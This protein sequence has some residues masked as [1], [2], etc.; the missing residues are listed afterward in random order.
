[1]TELY[2]KALLVVSAVLFSLPLTAKVTLP[3]F[4][5]S[6]MVL[7][8]NT[9]VSLPCRTSPG[10]EVTIST[11]FNNERE[12]VTADADGRFTYIIEV[13]DASMTPFWIRFSDG[14]TTLFN[15]LYSGEVWLCGGQSNMEMPIQGWGCVQNYEQEVANANYPMIRLL[16]VS[17]KLAFSPQEDAA[18]N[19][20]GW[21][22]CSPE[23]AANFS[24]LA[25]FFGREL[26][27]QLNVPIGLVYSAW[28]GTPCESWVS[29]ETAREVGGFESML[30]LYEQCGFDRDAILARDPNAENFQSPTLEYNAM[31]YPLRIMPIAGA[32]WYQGESNVGRDV[33]YSTLFKALINNWREIWNNDFPFYFVQLAGYLQPVEVQPGS[34]WAAL[35]WAQQKALE[36]P[37][38][39]MA[40]AIDVGNETDI[41]PK[42]KQEVGR[43]LALVA[44]KNTYGLD[45][46]DKAPALT[47]YSLTKRKAVLTFSAPLTV[48]ET[49][50][51]RGFILQTPTGSFVKGRATLE[52]DSTVSVTGTFTGTPISVRYNWADFPNGNLYGANDLPV[53]PFRTDDM[54]GVLN[55]IH[56]VTASEASTHAT[57]NVYTTDGILLRKG[58]ESGAAADDLPAGV[59]IVGSKK[60]LV[61]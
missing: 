49:I 20:G 34:Q 29:F 11:S 16:Q 6:G 32:I 56:S 36:L 8:H 26:Y 15:D 51:P 59:Y 4:F 53:L 25:Y 43:R 39:G 45:V 23:T 9:T 1:M 12:T 18:V 57:V 21:Q 14:E 58:V 50:Q 13:P 35:R 24:A 7:Q 33:Q 48:K 3:S 2:S 47:S 61:K 28:G 60:V 55:G 30:N 37:N 54:D 40:T 52:N 5:T 27:K 17:N 38:T 44:L 46:I 22:K 41:H 42:N 19:N 10:T 31:I